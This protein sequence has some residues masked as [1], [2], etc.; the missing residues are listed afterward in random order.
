MFIKSGLTDDQINHTHGFANKSEAERPRAA[1][2]PRGSTPRLSSIHGP[3]SRP[4]IGP[5]ATTHR[6]QTSYHPRSGAGNKGSYTQEPWE[7]EAFPT[8]D[9]YEYKDWDESWQQYPAEEYDDWKRKLIWKLSWL[10]SLTG[11]TGTCWTPMFLIH[12]WKKSAV[13]ITAC[14]KPIWLTRRLMTR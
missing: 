4:L 9:G 12:T 6:H 3:N 7:E 13:L 5:A 1:L 14:T 8:L 2:D 11:S 10:E